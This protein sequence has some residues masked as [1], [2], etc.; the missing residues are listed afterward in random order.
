M[1]QSGRCTGPGRRTPPRGRISCFWA[2]PWCTSLERQRSGFNG[3]H[4]ESPRHYLGCGDKGNS[5]QARPRKAGV[6]HWSSPLDRRHQEPLSFK[7]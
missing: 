1:V 7:G 5:P 4:V 6:H 2:G 3:Q